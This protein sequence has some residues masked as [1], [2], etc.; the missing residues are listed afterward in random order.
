MSM[1]R[2]RRWLRASLWLTASIGPVCVAEQA[3]QTDTSKLA[4]TV[5]L[6]AQEDHQRMMELLGI[7]ELRRGAN[8]RDQKAE[9]AANYDEAKANPYPELP[10]PLVLKN[11]KMVTTP[12]MWW[13]ERRPEIVED[14]DRDIYGRVPKETP[15]VTWEV[16]STTEGKNGDVPVVTKQLVGHVDNSSYPLVK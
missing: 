16:T 12:Q 7:K 1:S 3:T 6:T 10:D 5:Q 13:T 2:L 4:P 8:G 15:K 14:F 11:G 9:N